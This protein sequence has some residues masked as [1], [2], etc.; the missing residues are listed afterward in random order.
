MKFIALIIFTLCLFSCGCN[1]Q[2]K[3][4]AEQKADT[5]RKDFLPVQ[6]FIRSEIAWVD[7]F[8]SKMVKYTI[9]NGHKDSTIIDLKMFDSL[10]KDFLSPELEKPAFENNFTES[11]FMDQTSESLSFTYSAL[12]N[13]TA[14]RRVDVLATPS[15]ELD[16]VKSIYIEKTADGVDGKELKKMYW[17][18]K[19]NFQIVWI[20][21]NPNQSPATR[22]LKV[23]WDNRH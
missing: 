19:S 21:D 5:T 2:P 9:E 15:L 7:S 22:Q 20:Q 11:S 6:D 17:K 1:N 10:A 3:P 18:S 16:R 23:V 14:I 13:K 4:S 12:N 8:P